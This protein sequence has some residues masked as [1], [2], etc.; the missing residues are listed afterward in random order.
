MIER[1]WEYAQQSGVPL[2]IA[3][4]GGRQTGAAAGTGRAS[5]TLQETAQILGGIGVIASMFYV[6]IQI[7]NNARA[8]RAAT[9]QQLSVISIQGWLSMAHN[10]ETTG[11]MLRGMDDFSSLNRVE[12]GRFRFVVMGYVKG[13]ENAWFQNKIG[14][15]HENDWKAFTSDLHSFFSTPGTHA[16]WPIVKARFNA[17]FVA[18]I[19]DVLKQQQQVVANYKPPQLAPAQIS[20]R[21]SKT[22]RA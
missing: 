22:T 12:K 16:A 14:T 1:Y 8:M 15:L 13:F 6:G 2:A 10:G 7:R 5:M 11:I 21:K 19:D 4:V 20:P 17:E 3:S 18:F 9:Y